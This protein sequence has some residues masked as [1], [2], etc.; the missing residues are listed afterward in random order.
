MLADEKKDLSGRLARWSLQLQELDIEIFHRSG[1][2][3]SDA[4]VLSR[5]P[6]DQPGTMEDIPTLMILSTDVNRIK[7][8]Q[9]TSGWW[10]PIL[11]RLRSEEDSA[12]TRR[13]KNKY[14]IRDGILFRRVIWEGR[15][16]FRLCV[17]EGLIKEILLACHDDV[18]AGHLGITRTL[19][20]IRKRFFW[21]RFTQKVILYVRSCVDCQTKKRST[22]KRAGMMKSMS[23]PN[24]LKKWELIL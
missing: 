4:D 5:N 3:H 22:E 9:K 16:Y 14:V 15:E 8:G 18:T 21:P 7:N 20:K 12:T 23:L 2:L 1:K 11:E 17:P 19:D 24:H 13:L 10:K 6:V